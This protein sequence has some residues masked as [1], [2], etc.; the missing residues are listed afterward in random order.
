TV[1]SAMLAAFALAGL[2]WAYRRFRHPRQRFLLHIALIQIFAGLLLRL[3]CWRAGVPMSAIWVG[4]TMV[5]ATVYACGAAAVRAPW[6]LLT[7]PILFVP[8]LLV[9]EFGAPP[10]LV[11]V[12]WIVAVPVGLYFLRRSR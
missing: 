6:V 11:A 8:L 10:E 9:I 2:P 1:F 3:G 4:E 12:A 5:Y 7:L